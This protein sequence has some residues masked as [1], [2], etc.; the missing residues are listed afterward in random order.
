M[1]GEM[2]QVRLRLRMQ[3]NVSMLMAVMIVLGAG[4]IGLGRAQDD[5]GPTSAFFVSFDGGVGWQQVDLTLNCTATG[6]C[7]FNGIPAQTLRVSETVM[8][9]LLGGEFKVPISGVPMLS[10][11]M[12][13]SPA[14]IV[15]RI[16]SST[17]LKIRAGSSR[18]VPAPSLLS[19]FAI[20]AKCANRLAPDD[21]ATAV[22][23]G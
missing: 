9:T 7:G 21:I 6:A 15:R 11:T 12:S 2:A 18:R 23:R 17:S 20:P 8:G 1:R 5:E 3:R 4:M 10:R 14:G 22:P 13:S 19:E 16:S